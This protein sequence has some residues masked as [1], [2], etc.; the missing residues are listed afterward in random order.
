MEIN[1][2]STSLIGLRHEV[3]N[4]VASPGSGYK[5]RKLLSSGCHGNDWRLIDKKIYKLGSE[6]ACL[7]WCHVCACRR[8]TA[9]K[10]FWGSY[11]KIIINIC[12]HA[13]TYINIEKYTLHWR[14]LIHEPSKRL[15]HTLIYLN[16]NQLTKLS[17]CTQILLFKL[18]F[19][20]T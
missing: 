4:R 1:A 14:K 9:Y 17:Q 5:D 15:Y 6:L 2:L 10:I 19:L 16:L 18:W 12:S 11:F 20:S 13:H 7:V 8:I 3:V